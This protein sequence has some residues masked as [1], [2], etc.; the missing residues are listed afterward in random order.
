VR[1]ETLLLKAEALDLVEVLAR[2]KR[3]DIV[4]ADSWRR[5]EKRNA[6]VSESQSHAAF[7]RKGHDQLW[8]PLFGACKHSLERCDHLT[9]TA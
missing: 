2:L 7:L 5:S 6:N 9:F 8:V 3:N 4:R 1:I